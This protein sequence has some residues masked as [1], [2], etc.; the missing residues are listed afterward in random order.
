MTMSDKLKEALDEVTNDN[1]LV[2]GKTEYDRVITRLTETRS[3]LA[4]SRL[5]TSNLQAEVEKLRGQLE[6]ALVIAQAAMNDKQSFKVIEAEH[7][8][9]NEG[10]L[11]LE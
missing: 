4:R 10:L 6:D 8:L 5:T 7:R 1:V 11:K 9:I 2:V 3:A